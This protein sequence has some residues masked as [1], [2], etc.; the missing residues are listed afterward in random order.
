MLQ[1]ILDQL[2]SAETPDPWDMSAAE[3]RANFAVIAAMGAAP[4]KP[5]ESEDRSVPGPSGPIPIRIYRPIGDEP[6]TLPQPLPVV[7]FF[8]GGG[9]VIGS[10]ETH[11]PLCQQLA[12]Q[13][14]AVV[15]SVE[16]RLAPEHP[17]P[18][19]LKDAMAA[20]VWVA[21]H[22]VDIGVDAA[23]LAVAGD[24]A[25][26]NISTVVSRW[27][28]D[29]GGPPIAFQLLIYPEIELAGTYPSQR[30][31]GHGYLL[32]TEMNE[33]FIGH[34][35]GEQD[36]RNPDASP[37]YADDLSR[38]P[39]AFVITA[40]YDPLRDEGEAYAKRLI[41][42][43]VDARFVRYDG[44]IHGFAQMNA[45]LPGAT[46]AISEASQ[47]IRDA[48]YEGLEQPDFD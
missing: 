23:R 36:R 4:V 46:A 38:L 31:N 20:V 17:F 28:R 18:A 8:H 7:V 34:Y 29:S 44:M 14:P 35:L 22:A 27:A 15:V 11:E 39:P 33:W 26:G 5:P 12:V 42:A 13:V 41:D 40:E 45:I 9:W 37:I 30:E 47:A 1:A 3:V 6:A 25:G 16:Y 43:G 2:E 19:G 48:L 32:T 10:I 21:E 24:S